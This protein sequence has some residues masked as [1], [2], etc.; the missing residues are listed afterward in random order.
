M[1]TLKISMLALLLLIVNFAFA[2]QNPPKTPEDRANNQTKNLTEKLGL[3]ADQQKSVYTIA[4]QHAQQQNADRTKYQGDREGMRNARKQNMD[5]YDAGLSKILT[6]DQMTKYNQL[7]AE[8]KANR[9][10][11]G[12]QRGG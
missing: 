2:Q 9:Q 8:Q 1:K 12:G 4:L 3:S 6:T 10:Q 7:K 11:G 5:T